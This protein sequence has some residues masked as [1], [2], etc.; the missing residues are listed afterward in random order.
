MLESIGSIGKLSAELYY[1][2]VYVT[3]MAISREYYRHSNGY[4]ITVL[5]QSYHE[6]EVPVRKSAWFSAVG[7]V[8]SASFL[9]TWCS[10][11]IPNIDSS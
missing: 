8:K 9:Y 5:H 10:L 3:F 11:D 4:G 2:Y 6:Y 7:F 1:M